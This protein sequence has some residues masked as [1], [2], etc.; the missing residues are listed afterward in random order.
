MR[1]LL[2][3]RPVQAGAPVGSRLDLTALARAYAVPLGAAGWL[4]VNMVSTLDGAATGADGLTGSI[5]TEADHVV[6]RLLR[7]LSD[8]VVIGAGTARAEGYGPLRLPSR[9]ADL[10]AATGRARGLPLAVV[11]GSGRLPPA[12]LTRPG[13]RPPEDKDTG[14]VLAVTSQRAPGLAQLR[15]ELGGEQVI[16]A[17]NDEVDVVAALGH[18]QAR[19][20]RHVH[21]E[22]GPHLL[23][24]L[25]AAD[26]VD[27]LDLTYSPT[28]VGG[29][30]PRVVVG[31]N[32]HR[33]F[34]PR[35]LVEQD[36]TLLGRWLRERRPSASH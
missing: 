26:L 2:A 19:G 22:G 9:Y 32:L 29:T 20:M 13:S 6:F 7:A 14:A 18:L 31:T 16:I 36:G 30:H 15:R 8:V 4:R 12:L 21:C 10:R 33:T 11:T 35:L 24:R 3:D 1:L 25:L 5:N 23:G 34:L 27:E 17:G 28:A